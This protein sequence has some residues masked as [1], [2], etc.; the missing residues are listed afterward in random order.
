VCERDYDH[1]IKHNYACKPQQEWT[2]QLSASVLQVL[3][4]RIPGAVRPSPTCCACDLH[5]LYVGRMHLLAHPEVSVML[6]DDGS[7]SIMNYSPTVDEPFLY[8]TDRHS[9]SRFQLIAERSDR[10]TAMA[11]ETI[12]II[13]MD[14]LDVHDNVYDAQ[15]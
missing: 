5:V 2:V 3:Y 11:A 1:C 14:A 15:A 8:Q 4:A 9:N 13:L 6:L 7:Q 12:C 10:L